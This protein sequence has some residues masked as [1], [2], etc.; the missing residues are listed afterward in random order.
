VIVLAF[1]VDENL[2]VELAELLRAHGHDA[3]SVRDQNLGGRAVS[4]MSDLLAVSMVS[5]AAQRVHGAGL[6]VSMP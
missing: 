3:M 4:G 5:R 6:R 1:K 2:P